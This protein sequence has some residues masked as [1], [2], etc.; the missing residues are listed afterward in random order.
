VE[1]DLGRKK[2]HVKILEYSDP[3]KQTAGNFIIILFGP[4]LGRFNFSREI[5]AGA[6][7]ILVLSPKPDLST[8][9]IDFAS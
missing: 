5:N 7:L 8:N 4:V 2:Q 1:T 6:F 3:C 9:L